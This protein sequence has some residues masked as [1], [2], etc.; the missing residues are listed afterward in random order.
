MSNETI[1]SIVSDE[2]REDYLNKHPWMREYPYIRS[3]LKSRISHSGY[4]WRFNTIEKQQSYLYMTIMNLESLINTT[5]ISVL[6]AVLVTLRFTI[7]ES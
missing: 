1:N 2:K 4:A 5:D 3:F 6:N 7:Q